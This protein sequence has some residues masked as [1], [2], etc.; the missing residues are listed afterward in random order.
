MFQ[1]QVNMS[2]KGPR[3]TDVCVFLFFLSAVILSYSTVVFR[4]FRQNLERSRW[5]E[6]CSPKI[7]LFCACALGHLEPRWTYLTRCTRFL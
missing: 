4:N 5:Q 7:S 1:T 2:I 6:D 3:E